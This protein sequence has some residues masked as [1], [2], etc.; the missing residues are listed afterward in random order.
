MRERFLATWKALDAKTPG[1]PWYDRL[2]ACYQEP[3]RAYH[4]LE[5]IGA[6]LDLFE[7]LREQARDATAIEAAIWFHDAIY[8]TTASDNEEASALLAREALEDAGV[9]ASRIA[10]IA[11]IILDTRHNAEPASPDGALMVDVDLSIL[12]ADP[13]RF[14]AYEQ[15]IREEYAWVPEAA[16]KAGRSRILEG[17]L[18][19]TPIFH[20]PTLQ[21]RLEDQAIRNLKRS[22]HAL[23]SET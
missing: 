6:C 1:F 11:S 5:H 14:D 18:E 13:A 16:F 8:D 2:L 10:S 23:R 22:L 15:A 7:E 20:T 12:G 9:D 21:D 3:H 17:F 4:N 19:H